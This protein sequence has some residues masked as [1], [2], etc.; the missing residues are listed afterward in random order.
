MGW[1]SSQSQQC[2]QGPQQHLKPLWSG[3][4]TI[5]EAINNSSWKKNNLWEKKKIERGISDVL[6]P[7]QARWRSAA[8]CKVSQSPPKPS[9]WVHGAASIAH[10]LTVWK[11]PQHFVSNFAA[12]LLFWLFWQC[13]TAGGKIPKRKQFFPERPTLGTD[14][15]LIQHLGDEWN[16]GW[17]PNLISPH[18]CGAR[19]CPFGWTGT[20]SPKKQA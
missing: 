12:T 11:S 13:P 4:W 16:M 8:V 9:H 7:S 6:D 1:K 14:I 20:N 19:S 18:L 2:C 15:S 5:T 17:E 3:H 10:P